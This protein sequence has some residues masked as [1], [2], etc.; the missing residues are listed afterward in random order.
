MPRIPS[1]IAALSLLAAA[2]GSPA[3]AADFPPVTD[4]DRAMTQVAWE[5][6]AP[7]VVLFKR[8]KLKLQDYPNDVSSY[9]DVQ[10]RLKILTKEG[11]H[12]GEVVVP[13]SRYYRL[14]SF[15]GRTVLPDGRVVPLAADA[16]FKSETSHAE[17]TYVT[18]AAFPAVEVGAILD[19]SYRLIW[20]DFFFL[21]PWEFNDELPTL[22]SEV[23]YVIP[24]SLAIKP[25]GRQLTSNKIQAEKKSVSRGT[26]LKV[27]MDNLPSIADE[28]F[29]F[30]SADLSSRAMIVP[31]RVVVGSEIVLIFESWKTTCDL[32]NRG[33]A[34]VRRKDRQAKKSAREIAGAAT[35]PPKQALALYRFVRDEVRTEESAG[36]WAGE[37]SVDQVLTDRK[38]TAIEKALLLSTMLDSIGLEPH[39]VW[40]ADRTNGQIDPE[41]AN[42]YWFD[43]AVVMVDLEGER[44]FLDPSS[45]HL[46]FGHLEPEY[47][48]MSALVHSATKPENLTLPR[49]PF[50]RNARRAVVNLVIDAEGRATGTG[51]VEASGHHAFSF[52]AW[53]DGDKPVA[54]VWKEWLGGVFAGFDVGNLVVANSADDQQVQVAWSLAQRAEQALGD[55]ATLTPSLPLG[56]VKQAFNLP[57]EQRRT[58][59]QLTFAD[60]DEVELTVTWPVGWEVEALPPAARCENAAGTLVAGAEVEADAHRLRYH[61]RLDIVRTEFTTGPDYQ[62]I[63]GFYAEAE[64]HDAQSLV[65]VH[66]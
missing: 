49:P 20:D 1:L 55:E 18:K 36:V 66:R 40:A 17:K 52:L 48:G 10:V 30:P 3:R 11:L 16:V 56:P 7:A 61:R 62:A 47:E 64:R 59:V 38:G 9:L 39:L 2:V 27:W 25:W 5:P 29:S 32:F 44:V 46:G 60:R 45:R 14:N 35:D 4:A 23:S 43:R 13:H 6:G 42:P 15:A 24:G 50:D 12:Y 51:T 28:P 21:E 53:E 33:Y 57:V 54:D 63:R 22:R 34:D 8:A 41:V 58:P 65:L 37:G 31:L 19:Y 26:E